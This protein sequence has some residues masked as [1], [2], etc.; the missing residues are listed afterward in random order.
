MLNL[1]RTRLGSLS[2]GIVIGIRVVDLRRINEQI[3]RLYKFL[4]ETRILDARQQCGSHSFIARC[5][6]PSTSSKHPQIQLSPRPRLHH[7][8]PILP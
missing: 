6:P 3:V 8:L 5:L 1:Q 4:K 2:C 7:H